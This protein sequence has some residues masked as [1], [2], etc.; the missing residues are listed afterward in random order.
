[1]FAMRWDSDHADRRKVYNVYG[2]LPGDAQPIAWI[3]WVGGHVE[4]PDEGWVA[5]VAV[6]GRSEVARL[7]GYSFLED[8]KREVTERLVH[9]YGKLRFDVPEAIDEVDDG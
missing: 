2:Y 5:R 6:K 3:T 4:R 7:D 9:E 1:M 8:A